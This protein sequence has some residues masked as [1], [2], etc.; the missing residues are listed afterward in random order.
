MIYILLKSCLTMSTKDYHIS[1]LQAGSNFG[2]AP[3]NWVA[4]NSETL[5]CRGMIVRKVASSP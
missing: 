3:K 2:L 4:E 5:N 1:S